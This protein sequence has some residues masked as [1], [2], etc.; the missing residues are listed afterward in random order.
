MRLPNADQAASAYRSVERNVWTER[1][2]RFGYVTGGVVYI[3]IGLT[4]VLVALEHGGRLVSPEGAIE[5]IGNRSY[6]RILLSVAA[7]GLTGYAVWR[8]I[9]AISDVDHDGSDW[10]GILTRAGMICSG[11]GYGSL[12]V[13]AFRRAFGDH[14]GR[15]DAARHWTAELLR[16]SWGVALIVLI[17]LILI[18]AA[19]AEAIFAVTEKF[20]DRLRLGSVGSENRRWL[21]RFG[22]WGYLA[23]AIVM[24]L[25]GGFL[26]TA[27][28]TADARKALGLDGALRVLVQQEYGPWL[29]GIVA[30]GLTAYG[31]FML[32]E[33]Q[34]RKL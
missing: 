31:A 8:F 30:I 20:R 21:L 34:Y 2:A 28:V 4:A 27:A 15:H 12:A 22:M 7:I 1:W 29:L 18:S 13:F 33:A 3:L 19:I 32:V 5:V 11:I 25:I 26:I 6:G 23:Q 10:K 9:A 14:G 17:G 16:H 24:G